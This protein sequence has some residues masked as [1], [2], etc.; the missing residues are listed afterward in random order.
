MKKVL[1]IFLITVFLVGIVGADSGNISVSN[2]MAVKLAQGI[3]Y[4]DLRRGMGEGRKSAINQSL[5]WSRIRRNELLAEQNELL[6]ELVIILEQ[7]KRLRF[8]N[9]KGE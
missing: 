6:R 3:Q 4:R 7:Y 1:L 9:N 2:E 8:R 5:M